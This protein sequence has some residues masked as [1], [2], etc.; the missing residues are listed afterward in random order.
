MI[1]TAIFTRAPD[2]RPS[3][4]THNHLGEVDYK[5]LTRKELLLRL[6]EIA[7]LLVE[8]EGE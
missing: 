8:P 1:K 2:G 4:V 7:D 5:A 6:Q 3:L